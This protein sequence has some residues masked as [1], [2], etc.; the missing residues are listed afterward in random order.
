MEVR[1]A[2]SCLDT[3]RQDPHLTLS[4]V[5]LIKHAEPAM[6]RAVCGCAFSRQAPTLMAPRSLVHD[7]GPRAHHATDS[8]Q[9]PIDGLREHEAG[10]CQESVGRRRA[11]G[12]SIQRASVH[13][14]GCNQFLILVCMFAPPRP[15]HGTDAIVSG[16]LLASW[17]NSFSR[18]CVRQTNAHSHRTLR[19][20]SRMES[21]HAL[22]RW[23]PCLSVRRSGSTG[24]QVFSASTFA[25]AA[26]RPAPGP[27]S[28]ASSCPP[29][30][31]RGGSRLATRPSGG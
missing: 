9:G 4:D 6:S 14:D 7:H 16:L 21:P 27:A 17:R 31:P 3:N 25:G 29:G 24:S 1:Q 30:G 10:T 15:V 26:R 28:R 19:S 2:V 18:L 13:N 20:F 8:L 11:R 12:T 22:R 5:C 23:T